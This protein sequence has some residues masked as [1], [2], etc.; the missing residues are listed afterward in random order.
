VIGER[1][2]SHKERKKDREVTNVNR[3]QTPT[4]SQ[5]NAA[6]GTFEVK[7][8]RLTDRVDPRVTTMSIDKQIHGDL[9][10]T[11]KGEMLSAGDP[12]TGAAG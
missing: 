6:K 9:E 7:M 3:A 5:I 4:A 1:F 12:K 10:A 8:N 11:A 2:N